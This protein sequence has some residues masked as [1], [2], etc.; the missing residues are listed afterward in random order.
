MES[1]RRVSSI[2][3][4]F[5]ESEVGAG[6]RP[7]HGLVMSH[8]QKHFAGVR[9]LVDGCLEASHGEIHGLLG[10]N[11]AG[12]STMLRLLSGV[13]GPDGGEIELD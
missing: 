1:G 4:Q 3:K 11:G 5:D 12:K 10:E 7:S 6:E 2:V 8:V 9:A 13:I